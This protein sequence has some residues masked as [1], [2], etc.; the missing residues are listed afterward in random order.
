M[1]KPM[2]DSS[3]AKT[4]KIKRVAEPEKISDIAIYMLDSL[5]LSAFGHIYE[6][7]G[8]YWWVAIEGVNIVGFAGLTPFD[9]INTCLMC[10]A[11]VVSKYNRTDLH[12]RLVRVR[13]RIGKRDGN[14]RI[15][16]FVTRDNTVSSNDL[17]SLGYMLYDPPEEYG[18]PDSLYFQKFL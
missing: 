6:K 14:L 12:R 17:I 9:D 15:V 2:K 11:A 10:R 8:S 16:S 5:D 4:I 3:T 13:E 7:E 18:P 1:L